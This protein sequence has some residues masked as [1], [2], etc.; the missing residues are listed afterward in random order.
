[1]T[2]VNRVSR[3]VPLDPPTDDDD[4]ETPA[5]QACREGLARDTSRGVRTWQDI[6]NIYGSKSRWQN[7]VDGV[8]GGKVLPAWQQPRQRWIK[9]KD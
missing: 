9:R 3:I 7:I 8:K 2:R 4:I 1:M 5:E 6:D